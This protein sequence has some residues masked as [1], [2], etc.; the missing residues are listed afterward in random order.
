MRDAALLQLEQQPDDTGVL[1]EIFRSVHTIKG[2][3]E[4]LGMERIAELSHRLESLLDLLRRGEQ[5]VDGAVIDLLI[6][7]NDRIATLMNELEQHH[8]EESTID[9]LISRLDQIEQTRGTGAGAAQEQGS[10]SE[11]RQFAKTQY[12][13]EYDLE[14]FSIF[15][16]QLKQGLQ[17]LTT[18]T[19]Q[20]IGDSLPLP[21]L[22]RCEQ[23]LSRLCSSANYME[24][25]ELKQFYRQWQTRFV[26]WHSKLP[27]ERPSMSHRFEKGQWLPT[28]HAL[29]NF[30]LT[31]T[32]SRPLEPQTG[33]KRPHRCR[34]L[35]NRCP[36]MRYHR[37]W[38]LPWRP[39]LSW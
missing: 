20:L 33:L 17:F 7:G 16:T 38:C 11:K 21:L 35:R 1:N 31:S 8:R 28:S 3:S 2:S 12:G 29:K 15:M 4:Y 34:R 22:Q 5:A 13:E 37:K 24:Y 14:L 27:M 30:S 26:I 19:D 6:S 25:D 18:E 36:R 23:R 10:A 39:P 32:G 9:D